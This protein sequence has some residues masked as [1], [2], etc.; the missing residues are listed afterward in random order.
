MSEDRARPPIDLDAA[1]LDPGSVF[2]TPEDVLAQPGLSTAQRIEI[3][4]RWEYD[5]AESDVATE[6]G[7]PDGDNDLL[8]RIVLALETLAGGVDAERTGPSKQHGLP[9]SASKPK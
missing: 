2:A 5:A 8:R 4:R 3:L 6:E 9:S 1:L 7:M